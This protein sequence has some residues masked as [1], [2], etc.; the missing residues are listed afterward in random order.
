MELFVIGPE[1]GG[2]QAIGLAESSPARLEVLQAAGV[3]AELVIH[4]A[5]ALE[6]GVDRLALRAMTYRFRGKAKVSPW[7][8]IKPAEAVLALDLV[9]R[10][11]LDKREVAKPDYPALLTHLREAVFG[12]TQDAMA[13]IAG[14]NPSTYSRWEKGAADPG[15][16]QM[17][18]FRQLAV[19]LGLP[20]E[21]E[22]I[23]APPGAEKD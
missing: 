15:L 21:S 17:F 13:M 16:F 9:T 3:P 19:R 14:V 4:K 18:R 12:T 11:C 23:F 7:F 2:P 8:D 6:L 22:W 10:D 1:K 5:V 20:W